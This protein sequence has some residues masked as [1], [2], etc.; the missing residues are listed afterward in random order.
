M[1]PQVARIARHL[2]PGLAPLRA[3]ML[4]V[5]PDN[6]PADVRS[7]ND[8]ASLAA[9]LASAQDNNV[10]VAT[11]RRRA[12]I[13]P[14]YRT[15]V[16]QGA[17]PV[18]TGCAFLSAHCCKGETMPSDLCAMRPEGSESALRE[19]SYRLEQQGIPVIVTAAGQYIF[20]VHRLAVEALVDEIN[21]DLMQGGQTC[22]GNEWLHVTLRPARRACANAGWGGR[23]AG[24]SA[25]P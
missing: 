23:S 3:G 4:L 8:P 21:A 20:T 12:T 2:P 17:L 5:D 7:R 14:R 19:L 9:I 6:D 22:R 25:A 13:S 24:R 16:V 18:C 1:A 15:A 10:T 11:S